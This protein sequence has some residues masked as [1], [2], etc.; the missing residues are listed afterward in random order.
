MRITSEKS[1]WANFM[2]R[3]VWIVLCIVAF[4]S[5]AYMV[6]DSHIMHNIVVSPDPFSAVVAYLTVGGMAGLLLNWVFCQTPLGKVIDPSFTGITL[7]NRKA[8]LSAFLSGAIGALSTLFLLW[9]S[10]IFDPSLV[11]PLGNIAIF[12]VFL[13]EVS[14]SK[15][16]FRQAIVPVVLVVLGAMLF[17]YNPVAGTFISW[18]GFLVLVLLKNGVTAIGEILE[19]TGVLSGDATS[20][21]FWRFFWLTITGTILAV[22]VSLIR[23]QFAT[24]LTALGAAVHGLPWIALTMFLVFFGV[25]LKNAAKKYTNVSNV[26]M[27]MTIPI[28][29]GLP[30]TLLVNIFWPGTFVGVTFDVLTIVIRLAGALLILFGLIKARKD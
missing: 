3:N 23:G 21:G 2:S 15:V 27:F 29:L 4:V 6:N 30:L 22:T 9:G 1:W 24:Y 18:T 8:Q 11:L 19:Q 7:M 13:Y 17:T 28:V 26:M 12:F 5:A 16:N 20:F 14:G 25:G 10:Q